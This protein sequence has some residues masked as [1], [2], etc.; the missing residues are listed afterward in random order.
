[1]V[2]TEPGVFCRMVAIDRERHGQSRIILIVLNPDEDPKDAAR[3]WSK[4]YPDAV[5][6]FAL[7][8]RGG[9]PHMWTRK[10]PPNTVERS[11]P[12]LGQTVDY[13]RVRDVAAVLA[14]HGLIGG[15]QG[16]YRV[17]GRG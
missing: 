11:L 16:A 2:E 17:V 10:N 3:F 9:G 6:P 12:L 14:G 5:F 1:D 13:G 8:P 4:R 7:Y 15:I